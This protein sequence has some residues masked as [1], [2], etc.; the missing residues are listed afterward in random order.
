MKKISAF[1]IAVVGCALVSGVV[2]EAVVSGRGVIFGVLSGFAYSLYGI[3][4]LLYMKKNKEPLAFTAQSFIFAAI[5][6]LFI[7]NPIEIVKT[8][9]ELPN[10]WLVFAA[11]VVFGLFTSV[12]PFALYTVGL[13]GVSAS[14]ASIL[15]FSEPLT[16]AVLGITVLGQA[17]D[18]FGALGIVLVVTAIVILNLPS[19]KDKKTY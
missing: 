2:G 15:A 6:S 9:V 17:L 3:L 4:T 13:S 14:T 10:P 1:I 11:F 18:I 19:R 12:F 7:A 8:A 16:A 5:G